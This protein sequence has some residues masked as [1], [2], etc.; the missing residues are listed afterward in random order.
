MAV[1]AFVKKWTTA[2]ERVPAKESVAVK[3]ASLIALTTLPTNERDAVNEREMRLVRDASVESVALNFFPVDFTRLAEVESV[4]VNAFKND[5]DTARLPANER[6]AVNPR[7][8]DLDTARFPTKDKVAVNPASS[9]RLTSDPV[10][11]SVAKNPASVIFLMSEAANERVAEK[12]LEVRSDSAAL[13]ERVA[14]KAC[15]NR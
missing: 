14:V 1:N 7:I 6:L 2:V 13:V 3:P 11:E 5:F 10:N 4:A 12:T 8:K 15:V 9:S